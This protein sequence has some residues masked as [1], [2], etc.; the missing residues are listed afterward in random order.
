MTNFKPTYHLHRSTFFT[1][2]AKQMQHVP[3]TQH[4][5]NPGLP[6]RHPCVIWKT[7]MY[8]LYAGFLLLLSCVYVCRCVCSTSSSC[9]WSWALRSRLA[10]W[11][12]SIRTRYVVTLVFFLLVVMGIEIAAGVLALVYKDKVCSHSCLLPSRG[13]GHWDRGWRPGSRL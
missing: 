2:T 12:S 13:H 11:L 7:T 1:L 10:S 8:S 6:Q 9:S 5:L 4:S 3:V